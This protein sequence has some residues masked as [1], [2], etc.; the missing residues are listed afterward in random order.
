[1]SQLAI[2]GVQRTIAPGVF[3][4]RELLTNLEG[5]ALGQNEVIAS[6]KFDGEDVLQFREDA[7]LGRPLQ[8]IGEI[9][10]EAVAMEELTK[11]A[12]TDATA[13][14]QSVTAAL[15]DTADNYRNQ[16]VDLANGKL[17]QILEGI[18]LF[19]ALIRGV[20]LS[21]D[22]ISASDK[23][24]VEES[25]EQMRPA[26]ES[27]IEARSRH[28]WTLTADLLEYEVLADLGSFETTLAAFSRKLEAM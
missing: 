28:D 13:Y 16:Q 25:F 17:Q 24:V 9:S 3:T 1:M 22:G 11:N 23:S 20:E 19:V 7:V 6:V 14:L 8:S 21:I 18:K 27:L 15:V 26:L 4:W 2:N 10:V 12:I 5:S